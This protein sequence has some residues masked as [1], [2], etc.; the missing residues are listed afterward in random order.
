MPSHL[1]INLALLI[2]FVFYMVIQ[3]DKKIENQRI[4]EVNEK[5]Q[6]IGG[7]LS[8]MVNEI[9][10]ELADGLNNAMSLPENK[11]NIIRGVN[12]KFFAIKWGAISLLSYLFSC[13]VVN[14]VT[15]KK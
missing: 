4:V 6:Q 8:E 1:K 12:E 3:I 5:I 7:E 11:K 2:M 14:Y 13:F 9:D 15:K 10:V